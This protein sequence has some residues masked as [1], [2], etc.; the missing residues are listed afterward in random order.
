MVVTSVLTHR[1]SSAPRTH[2]L[3]LIAV[4]CCVNTR[5]IVQLERLGKLKEFMNLIGT[6]THD[7]P[8]FSIVPQPCYQAPPT[9]VHLMLRKL[10][11]TAT[12]EYVLHVI[13]SINSKHKSPLIK[14]N[15]LIKPWVEE[16]YILDY[17]TAPSVECQQ[18]SWSNL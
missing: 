17:N 9:L 11:L 7:L 2:F 16:S 12:H 18:T 3:I 14:L 5:A 8:A 10:H 1:P 15:L 6:Q 4:R 13:E